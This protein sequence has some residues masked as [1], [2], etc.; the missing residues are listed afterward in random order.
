MKTASCV[1]VVIGAALVLAL[2][3]PTA[4]ALDVLI[5]DDYFVGDLD[6]LETALVGHSVIHLDNTDAAND[7]VVTDNADFMANF[8]VVIFYGS[9]VGDSGRQISVAES[10]ALEAYI[11]GGGSLIAT[12]YD[13]LGSPDDSSLADVVRSSTFGDEL[14]ILSWTAADV[15]HFIL[16][17]PFGD[18]RGETIS[19]AETNHDQLTA[20]GARGA[21]ALGSL[22]GSTYEKIVFTDLPAP[23]GSVGMWNG[24]GA[25]NDWDPLAPGGN[26]GLKILRNWLAGLADADGDG[27]FDAD[28]NCPDDANPDQADGDGDDLGDACDNCPVVANPDQADGDGDDLG[29]ACDNCADVANSDQADGDSDGVGDACETQGCCGASGPVAPL[30]L[31]VGMLLLSRFTGYR[32]MRRR[33]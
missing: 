11:Q 8:D 9:G 4:K 25:G 1:C 28:D 32:R 29:D 5:A 30:G 33:R 24:N 16:N 13:V 14:G 6:F 7:P 2:G 23:G 27:V 26:D 12:G 20:D 22:S 18:Y 31:A 17:G 21:V 10:V 3:A 15:N 19:P